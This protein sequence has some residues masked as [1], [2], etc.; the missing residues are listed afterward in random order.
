[1]DDWEED[2]IDSSQFLPKKSDTLLPSFQRKQKTK[3]Q[4][5]KSMVSELNRLVVERDK[6]INQRII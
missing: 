2:G 4:K 1:M 3:D 5:S 6:I